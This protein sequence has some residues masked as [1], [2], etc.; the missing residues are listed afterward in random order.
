MYCA[1]EIVTNFSLVRYYAP[2]RMDDKHTLPR[3]TL[4]DFEAIWNPHRRQFTKAF[5]IKLNSRFRFLNRHEDAESF[6]RS[7]CVGGT[8]QYYRNKFKSPKGNPVRWF[9]D[10]HEFTEE[11][12]YG[13]HVSLKP[14]FKLL[15]LPLGK[16]AYESEIDENDDMSDE[17]ESKIDENA[18]MSDEVSGPVNKSKIDENAET[19]VNI[20]NIFDDSGEE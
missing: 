14:F 2:F 10:G 18:E 3:I 4:C 20:E 17:D 11:K 12:G 7:F 19:P 9:Q 13:I 5:V 1:A 16:N 6:I 15:C 8:H